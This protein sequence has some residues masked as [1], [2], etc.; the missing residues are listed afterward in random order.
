MQTPVRDQVETP[1]PSDI[2]ARL[3]VPT[4]GDVRAFAMS[5]NCVL[6]WFVDAI[7]PSE[8]RGRGRPP[9]PPAIDLPVL[10]WYT[11]FPEAICGP[12]ELCPFEWVELDNRPQ[13][14]LYRDGWYLYVESWSSQTMDVLSLKAIKDKTGKFRWVVRIPQ[15]ERVEGFREALESADIFWSIEEETTPTVYLSRLVLANARI[16]VTYLFNWDS[17]AQDCIPY[18]HAIEAHHVHSTHDDRLKSI[19]ALPNSIHHYVEWGR[20]NVV[21]SLKEKKLKE[22]LFEASSIRLNFY[23]LPYSGDETEPEED[24]VGQPISLQDVNPPDLSEFDDDPDPQMSD[25]TRDL[26]ERQEMQEL[27]LC[28]Q[29]DHDFDDHWCQ[30]IYLP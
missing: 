5:R 23:P 14:S 24:F 2:A 12:I 27:G 30:G 18:P 20:G 6:G 29:G 15:I 13:F 9:N 4:E 8:K 25:A 7:A 3:Q 19:L 10:E 28:I 17:E 21:D 1:A 16:V 11:V 22:I 26:L